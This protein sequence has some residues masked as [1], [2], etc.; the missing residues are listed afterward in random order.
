MIPLKSKF[1]A[2]LLT[3]VASAAGI[4][5]YIAAGLGQ[6]NAS[7][8]VSTK[9]SSIN[10]ETSPRWSNATSVS[11]SHNS[12]ATSHGT[13]TSHA[14][15]TSHGSS[16]HVTGTSSRLITATGITKAT[17]NVTTNGTL[18]CWDQWTNYWSTE[19]SSSL[20]TVTETTSYTWTSTSTEFS[21]Y[22]GAQ[23]SIE[24][25]AY[26]ETVFE[27]PNDD[28]YPIS[29]ETQYETNTDIESG[30][31]IPISTVGTYTSAWTSTTVWS[32]RSAVNATNTP[33][34]TLPSYVPQCQAQ[35]NQWTPGGTPPKCSQAS[36]NNQKCS[37][38]IA[39]RFAGYTTGNPALNAWSVTEISLGPSS[40]TES[41]SWPATESLAPGCTLGCGT[42]AIT[43]NT[44]Q[45]YYW[46][47]TTAT[48]F[49]NGNGTVTA[50]A[51]ALSP[52]NSV[53]I[54]AIVGGVT[55][56]SP[57]IYISYDTIYASDSCSGIGRTITNTVIPISSN[58]LSSLAYSAVGTWA[59]APGEWGVEQMPWLYVN[60][61]FNLS[62]LIEPIPNNV[63]DKL[64]FCQRDLRGWEMAGWNESS[65]I[66]SYGKLPY[67]P[68]I[69][70]P[71][72]V[73]NLD[74]AWGS[75][76]AWYG[77]LFE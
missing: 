54:T 28:K 48:L 49:E 65:F 2:C 57:T 63:Y 76:T 61:A 39:E 38:V 35:W 72:A 44:V 21:T 26:T 5:D 71:T 37:S 10:A 15:A 17:T 52:N 70:M 74:P 53:P 36:I 47:P 58:D 62:D 20:F 18:A 64:P 8:L 27:D 34:C 55:L 31:L 75:C 45:L 22:T 11:G 4:G 73:R 29:T 40:W 42:C 67:A 60:Q 30:A 19:T 33:S 1:A 13:T 6:A 66:C 77:G 12:T 59:V 41:S 69:A 56:T 51:S 43:G 24:T 16:A 50:R 32:G 68:L 25:L 7:G 9:Q 3:T 14:S 46:P 23:T